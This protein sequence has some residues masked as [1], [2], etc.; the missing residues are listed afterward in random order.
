MPSWYYFVRPASPS[1]FD[2]RSNK[3]EPISYYIKSLLG[4]SLKFCPTPRYTTN[5]STINHTLSRHQRDLWLKNYFSND[6]LLDDDYNPR[7]HAKSTWMPPEWKI[8][9]ELQRRFQD[10]SLHYKRLFEQKHGR[11]N[12]LPSQRI[13]LQ[14]LQQSKKLMVVQCDKNLGPALIETDTY[15]NMAFRDHLSKTDTYKHLSLHEAQT[16]GDDIRKLLK[17]WLKKWKDILPNSEKRFIRQAINDP[18]TETLSTFYLL[19]KVHKTP[20]ASRPIVSCSGTLLHSLG[21]WVDDKLQRVVLLQHSYFKSSTTL[22]EQLVEMNNLNE[23]NKLFTA[24]AISMYTNINTNK[25]LR[26]IARY[27]NTQQHL[28]PDVPVSALME[29]LD[30]IMNNNIFSFGDTYWHQISGTAMGTPPAPPYATL[31]YSIHEAILLE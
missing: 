5:N 28:F 13:A 25:A 27:L 7:L 6:P 11:S 15:I 26:E 14:Q 18:K 30:I 23:Y 10:F 24:D 4:L 2:L 17:D 29:A 31:F 22:K 21:I 3:N 8:N 9:K 19:M 16:F 20:L 12:L 1:F